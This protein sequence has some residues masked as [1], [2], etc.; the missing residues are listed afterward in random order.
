MNRVKIGAS[1]TSIGLAFALSANGQSV[2]VPISFEDATGIEFTDNIDRRANGLVQNGQSVL[3]DT[4]GSKKDGIMYPGNLQVD[5][6]SSRFDPNFQGIFTGQSALLLGTSGDTTWDNGKKQSVMSVTSE[7]TVDGW[8]QP[9]AFYANGASDLDALEVGGVSGESDAQLYSINGDFDGVSVWDYNDGDPKAW[10]M[11][12][13]LDAALG[14]NGTGVHADL[15]AFIAFGDQMILSIRGIN[16]YYDGGELW[17]YV[18]GSGVAAEFL[19]FGGVTWNTEFDSGF[20]LG[21]KG[22]VSETDIIAA[23]GVVPEP[24]T[25][26]AM[27]AGALAMLRRRRR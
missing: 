22:H 9:I 26:T 2:M 20:F 18:R 19:T 21:C 14:L 13:E 16:G 1:V 17:T 23:V 25:L 24:A 3:V 12:S 27:A 11:Q 8:A 5:A 4:D 6:L 10:L 7:G 15:D